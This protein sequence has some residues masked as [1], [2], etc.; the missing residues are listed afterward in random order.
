MTTQRGEA[1]AMLRPATDPAGRKAAVLL[2]RYPLWLAGVTALLTRIGVEVLGTTET[3]EEVGFLVREHEPDLLVAETRIENGGTP[4]PP[5][6]SQALEIRPEL[7]IV[8]LGAS[9]DAADI[10]EAFDA[11]AV[12]YVVKTTHPDDIAS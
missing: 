2:D 3:A 8:V 11:G 10:N 4:V 6:L 5:A 12:A 1:E 7:K 9:T